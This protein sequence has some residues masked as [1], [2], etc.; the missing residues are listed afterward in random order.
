[1]L[2]LINFIWCF[3]IFIQMKLPP[4][5]TAPYVAWI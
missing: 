3:S 4:G 2:L 5:S 1:M